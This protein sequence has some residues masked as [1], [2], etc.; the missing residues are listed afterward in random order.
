M[1]QINFLKVLALLFVAT[2]GLNA[3]SPFVQWNFGASPGTDVP[4]L[5]T[6][7]ISV[8]GG[9]TQNYASGVG[10]TDTSGTTAATNQAYNTT[11]YA[12]LGTE[13]KQRG[14]QMDVSTV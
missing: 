7:T 12:A 1:K 9:V 10:S 6:G 5:G 13:N 4:V 8:I 2:T 14:V 3:Q 11:T